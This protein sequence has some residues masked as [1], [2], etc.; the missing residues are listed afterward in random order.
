MLLALN[1]K[2]VDSGNSTL[3]ESGVNIYQHWKQN[4]ESQAQDVFSSQNLKQA[5][6][7]RIGSI[8][9]TFALLLEVW[10]RNGCWRSL[11][12]IIS[13]L[14][15]WDVLE[16]HWFL[17]WHCLFRETSW[18]CKQHWETEAHKVFVNISIL[19]LKWAGMP[20]FLQGLL[21]LFMLRY[22]WKNNI[23]LSKTEI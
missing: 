20:S 4:W 8:W 3:Q 21:T 16:C 9:Q 7:P 6:I 17:S 2:A 5:R 23:H 12:Q 10:L 19:R 13:Q 14:P 18:S 11:C 1:I 15:S 22:S